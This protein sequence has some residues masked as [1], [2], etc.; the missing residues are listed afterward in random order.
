MPGATK[1]KTSGNSLELW[2][3][4][5]IIVEGDE[6]FS[7]YVTRVEDIDDGFILTSRPTLVEGNHL[8]TENRPVYLQ[9]SRPDALYRFR[10]RMST[11]RNGRAG[12]VQFTDFG[13]IQRVQRREFARVEMKLELKYCVIK[14][15]GIVLDKNNTFWYDS[16]T[17]N[18]SAGGLLMKVHNK[19]EV[20]DIIVIRIAEYH[21]MGIPRLVSAVCCRVTNINERKFAGVQFLTDDRLKKHFGDEELRRLPPQ[22]TRFTRLIQNKMVKFIFEE[23]IKR[24][25]KG[26][27]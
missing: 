27:L 7:L 4:L 20:G 17:L 23:Q 26:L 22:P 10:A 5:E 11:P 21:Q 8:L 2:E 13:T 24:R 25:Q 1:T 6:R 19:M 12:Q 18:A 3:K 14:T 15:D 9:Y 16:Y